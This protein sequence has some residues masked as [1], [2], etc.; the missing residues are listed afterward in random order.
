MRAALRA[1]SILLGLVWVWGAVTLV[2]Q[3]D[4]AYELVVRVVGEPPR[5]KVVYA[6]WAAVEGGLGAAMLAGACRGLLAS[7]AALGALSAVLVDAQSRHGGTLKC[8]CLAFVPGEDVGTAIARNAVLG[9]L[10]LGLGVA[11]LV[12]DRRARGAAAD[13]GRA[14]A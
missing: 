2:V 9:A 1:A 5:S 7:A 4:H 3:P 8:G 13:A 12:I 6:L 10:A 11:A 14:T